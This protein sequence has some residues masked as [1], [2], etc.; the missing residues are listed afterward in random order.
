MYR[1]W[2]V[3]LALTVLMP[4]ANAEFVT[5]NGINYT[6]NYENGTAVCTGGGNGDVVIGTP[7][8]HSSGDIKVIGIESEA[9]KNNK[10]ITSVTLIGGISK[11]G[12]GAFKQCMNLKSLIIKSPVKYMGEYTFE[13]CT[14]LREVQLGDSLTSIGV[15]T[16]FKCPITSISLP[17][18]LKCIEDSAF[19]DCK[20]LKEI[21]FN[22][23]LERIGTNVFSGCNLEKI[24]L[25]ES[26]EEIGEYAFANGIAT[27]LRST[28]II[29]S[30]VKII[31]KGAFKFCY[32]SHIQL[33]D[34]KTELTIEDGN[35]TKCNDSYSSSYSL[36]FGRNLS[37]NSIQFNNDSLISNIQIGNNIEII[38]AH[39]FENCAN[40]RKA[41]L[42]ESVIE[43]GDYAFAN[44][45]LLSDVSFVE[46]PM[47]AVRCPLTRIGRYAF[48]GTCDWSLLKFPDTITTI[49]EGAFSNCGEISTIWWPA[50]INRIPYKCF[51]NVSCG[52][53]QMDECDTEL[54]IDVRSMPQ[55][56]NRL[57]LKRPIDKTNWHQFG[58]NHETYYVYIG[59]GNKIIP[60]CAF[61]NSSL[62]DVKISDE[63]E[64]I[65]YSAFAMCTGLTEIQIPNSVTTIGNT[66]FRNCT[67]LKRVSLGNS[68]RHMGSSV[69][70]GSDNIII[71]QSLNENPPKIDGFRPF[72]DEVYNN[73]SL[74]VPWQSGNLY[75][76]AFGWKD[77]VTL[78][79]E[80]PPYSSL[81]VEPSKV[82]LYQ[83]ERL[84]IKIQPKYNNDSLEASPSFNYDFI[85][86][87]SN[88]D[89]VYADTD[90]NDNYTIHLLGLKIGSAVLTISSKKY[91]DIKCECIINVKPIENITLSM[92][93]C[94]LKERESITL[95]AII[96]PAEAKSATLIWSTNE[97]IVS[98]NNISDNQNSIITGV[99]AGKTKIVVA[100]TDG[101][102]L[103]A[104]C[105]IEVLPIAHSIGFV[106]TN[107]D[108]IHKGEQAQLSVNIY[109]DSADKTLKWCSTNTEVVIV[110]DN[111]VIT[112]VNE[113][114]ARIVA[115][116]Q[117]GSNLSID[118]MIDVIGPY[119]SSISLD[120]ISIE[121]IEGEQ[122]QINA[123]VLPEDAT[124]K[125]LAWRSSDESVATVDN[126]G[127]VSLLQEGTATITASA[128]DGSGVS[129]E[130]AVAVTKNA[131]IED[132][133]TD[134]NTYVKIFNL[135]GIL[136]YEGIY[137]VAKLVPDYY[138]VVCDGK[139]IKIKVD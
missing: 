46:G 4:S 98:I 38:P 96:T 111:G 65:E 58:E 34:G 2:F 32:F 91:P 48:A 131:G 61:I 15:K 75:R 74:L 60:E 78:T 17:T 26:L 113:G 132:I 100:T 94:K 126:N 109:P 124:N 105:D 70:E 49:G 20:S 39:A 112:G 122:I 129:A 8:S 51:E 7:L 71:V 14:M 50:T 130:C 88:R 6:V 85:C 139:N 63:V 77:F 53:F 35:F 84:D 82:E 95:S 9:F 115:S 45:P 92:S 24:D 93:T 69:F 72:T 40:L 62:Q 25:P 37:S 117:D 16:F 76:D 31:R 116:T 30:Q 106:A 138:I 110:D 22:N 107:R 44:C 41:Y 66:A 135:S 125:L 23:K 119:I 128:T 123:T 134:K 43:I 87:L 103:S 29:P 136:V 97:K 1:F 79:E 47:N 121:G 59:H 13:K 99:N 57:Y 67:N 83:N 137:S 89:I 18:A 108:I 86:E 133:L 90:F 104:E 102:N 42:G 52:S 3:I 55:T 114:Y 120:P 36:Y 73:A 27:A 64:S 81:C 56:I 21:N 19:Y 68:I 33:S 101:S 5:V 80:A 11:I 118:C 54:K 127:L 10:D 12:D 28:L